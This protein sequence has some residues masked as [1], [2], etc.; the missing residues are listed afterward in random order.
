[1]EDKEKYITI[2]LDIHGGAWIMGDK[3]EPSIFCKDDLYKDFI[4]AT[5]SHTLLNGKYKEYNLFRIID[6]IDAALKTLKNFLIK[7]VFKKAN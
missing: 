5:M 6:E 7:K 2:L 4:V 1:M 3:N